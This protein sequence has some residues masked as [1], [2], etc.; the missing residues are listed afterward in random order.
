MAG[1]SHQP[2]PNR[3]SK[4]RAAAFWRHV[5]FGAGWLFLAIGVAGIFLPLVPGTLFLILSAAC[6]TRSSPRF[7]A[8]LLDHPRLGPPIRQWRET[9]AIPRHVKVYACL[10]LVASWLVVLVTGAPEAVT[11]G[12]LVLFV[13]VGAYIATRPER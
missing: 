5:L 9:G 8:W 3:T 2:T 12:L 7:E 4:R 13:A 6:F 1:R 11:V 10:S